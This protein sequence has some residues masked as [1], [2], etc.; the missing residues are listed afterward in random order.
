MEGNTQIDHKAASRR[1]HHA[2]ED[3]IMSDILQ[4]SRLAH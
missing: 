1:S 2:T 4:F 3:I